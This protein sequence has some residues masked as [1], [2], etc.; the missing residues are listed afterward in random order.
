[1]RKLIDAAL[2]IIVSTCASA[3]ELEFDH[4]HVDGGWN[5]KAGFVSDSD[6]H[7]RLFNTRG[8]SRETLNERAEWLATQY[9]AKVSEES[10]ARA[11]K[12]K[13][14]Y[15]HAV[16]I[17]SLL[18]CS[19]GIVGNTPAT[20][21]K[22]LERNREAN[23]TLSSSTVFATYGQGPADK[24]VYEVVADSDKV[25]ADL[26][27][28]KAL[29][30]DDIR[31]AKSEDSM[32]VVYNTQGSDFVIENLADHAKRA[33]AHG[34]R[35]M[36]FVYNLNNALA[37][38][39]SKQN[40][41]LTDMGRHWVQIAQA[42]GILL[43]VSHSS[44]QTAIDAAAIA[45]KPIIASHSNAQS[46][47]NVSRNISDEAIK[48]IASTG[49]VICPSGVGLHLNADGEATPKRYLEHVI[50]VADLVGK[51]R[52]CFASDYVHNVLDYYK[53]G[54][55]KTDIYP[56]ELGFGAPTSNLAAEHIWHVVALLE[57]E[58]DWTEEE[59]VGFLGENLMRVYQTSW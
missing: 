17:N 1:M 56:P 43:D 12:A 55:D 47:F 2:V 49:G 9:D 24:T 16:T 42:N 7:A 38:G 22:A 14:K 37:G 46:L 41:G 59:I 21:R 36:N 32:A 19:V 35:I 33:Y 20:F 30:V 6:I 26:G 29:S 25:V 58:H 3:H 40:Q 28:T 57:D 45:T 5:A 11:E 4:V 54:L 8:K 13:E 48:A 18:P 34:I 53:K 51:D 50:H 15:G 39:G 27:L 23:F 52:V 31:R 44:N 10:I